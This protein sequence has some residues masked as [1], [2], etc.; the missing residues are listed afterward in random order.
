MCYLFHV[1]F[2]FIVVDEDPSYLPFGDLI[3]VSS[4][5]VP[6][7]HYRGVA[8]HLKLNKTGVPMRKLLS[9]NEN[10][11]NILSVF[12]VEGSAL[13]N[14]SNFEDRLVSYCQQM[15]SRAWRSGEEVNPSWFLSHRGMTLLHL[16]ASL[17]YSR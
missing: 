13:F 10:A 8:F 17:G 15:T 4:H 16:A 14:Q 9:N 2:G 7:C 3:V 12:Q 5:V 1:R 6:N 11:K